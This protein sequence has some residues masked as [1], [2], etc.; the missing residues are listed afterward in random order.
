MVECDDD[1]ATLGNGAVQP[2][3]D[4]LPFRF[5]GFGALVGEHR[6]ANLRKRMGAQPADQ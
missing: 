5:G 1:E 2:V 3:Q 4:I 6:N